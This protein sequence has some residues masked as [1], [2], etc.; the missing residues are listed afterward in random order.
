MGDFEGIGELGNKVFGGKEIVLF[1]LLF[2]Y[3][4][5]VYLYL[6]WL[7]LNYFKVMRICFQLENEGECGGKEG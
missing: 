6:R 5:L 1:Q 2:N 4:G 7:K 3:D